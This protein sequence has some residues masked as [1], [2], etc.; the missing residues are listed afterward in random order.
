M[1]T[2]EAAGARGEEGRGAAVACLTRH[3]SNIAKARWAETTRSRMIG[4]V[5]QYTMR[6]F[7]DVRKRMHSRGGRAKSGPGWI[8]KDT[9]CAT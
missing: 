7:R 2:S 6:E 5:I 1:G 8:G 9:R 3:T 4:G